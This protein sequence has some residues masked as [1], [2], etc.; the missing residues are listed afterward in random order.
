MY[1]ER[2]DER[3]RKAQR[4]KERSESRRA[5]ARAWARVRGIP[6]RI[7]DG[8]VTRELMSVENGVPI[9][10]STLNYNAAI[11]TA[12]DKVR[13]TVP[14]NLDG[15]GII[16]GV[17]D[18]GEA[19]ISHQEFG[20]RCY[21][22]NSANPHYHATHVAGTIGAAGV[23]PTAKGM[24]P[25]ATIYSYDWA[26]HISE[27]TTAAAAEAGRNDKIYLSN[28]SYS[29]PG[30]WNDDTWHGTNIF[31]QYHAYTEELDELVYDAQFYLP[32]WA[33][34]NDRN[35]NGT[36]HPG[37][38]E[39]KNGF[40]TIHHHALA[41][42]CMTVGAVSK[43]VSGTS[44]S[45]GAANMSSFS[46][47]GPADDGRIKPDIVAD[48]VS[49]YSC[50]IANNS[51]YDDRSGTS[52][53][54][55]NACGSAALLVE[56]Y[57]EQFSGS[58]MRASTLKGL[59][60]HTADDMGR[61][62]PDYEY[63]W[64][65]MDTRAAANLLKAHAEGN[66]V[67]LSED[68]LGA[69]DKD[70]SY[71][72]R[73]NGVEPIRATLCWTDPPGSVKTAGDDRSPDLVNDLDLKVVGPDGTHYPFKLS[74][75]TPTANA[76]ATEENDVDNV[77]QVLIEVPVMGQYTVIV[78]YDG[79][80]SGGTQWYSLLISG[81]AVD[82][83]T[84]GMDDAWE[85][86]YF[87]STTGALASADSDLDGLNNLNEYISGTD[88][89]DADSVFRVVWHRA[90]P[91]NGVPFSVEWVPVEG[92]IYNVM[93]SSGLVN[94]LF[95]DISGD[96]PYPASNYVD[97]VDRSLEDPVFYQIGVRLP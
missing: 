78:D 87:G 93:H 50:D 86:A 77:E 31:G 53:A 84:D 63:G 48:G 22:I 65:L 90:G 51:D 52:M 42:N 89:K 82:L 94:N 55:P 96:L 29:W 36:G 81:N 17:W 40:D 74:Y 72:F 2:P 24:A 19:L 20:G 57:K 25:A 76:T 12:A 27:M 56:Y 32:F 13:T 5:H 67:V 70:D 73:W 46:S 60:I 66:V 37:D 28:H 64:G 80:L 6:T 34:G 38:G 62:G 68:T 16:V 43:A 26:S 47:W 21:D 69:A 1:A 11:T 41:K 8:I 61:P 14:F 18:A 15:D 33:A 92:R 4:H 10:V 23:S 9:Y 7:D 49:V 85:V 71:S 95:E 75:A 3:I 45:L 83:D 88:P 54:S 59:I 35:D 39:Y 30:G 58:A 79:P 44:R 97:H 91:S